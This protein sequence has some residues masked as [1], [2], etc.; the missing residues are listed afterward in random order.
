MENITPDLLE[1]KKLLTFHTQIIFFSGARWL[2]FFFIF[3]LIVWAQIPAMVISVLGFVLA[4]PILPGVAAALS[5]SNL[6]I[7][8][9]VSP[10]VAAKLMS[11]LER[12]QGT[13]I[14]LKEFMLGMMLGFFPS[15][16]FYG[17]V[18]V[19]EIADQARGDIGG[20]SADGGQIPMTDAGIILYLVGAATFIAS[21]E[22]LNVIKLLFMSYETWPLFELSNFITP[23]KIHFYL[24]MSMRMMFSTIYM[25]LPFV[26]LMW[27]YDIQTAY[28]AKT[29]K[30]FQAQEYQFALKNFTFIFFMILYLKHNELG[31]YHPTMSIATNF[32]AIIEGG[33]RE[34]INHGR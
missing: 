28:Q 6:V 18:M 17:F 8:P 25:G 13:M 33:G 7:W 21:G 16:F 30:K 32:A 15:A 22:F 14:I 1:F 29:D 11:V 10:D 19:G 26:V 20:R 12:K 2:G 24:D 5:E 27:S 3:P 34:V 9:I 31:Q 4:L 23:E